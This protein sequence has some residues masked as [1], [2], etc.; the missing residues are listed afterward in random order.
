MNFIHKLGK[1]DAV[2]DQRTLQLANYIKTLPVLPAKVNWSSKLTRPWGMMKN[3][4]V[5][6]CT[7]AAAGHM[8]MSWAAD[9][10][11][12]VNI[13][14]GDIIRSYV[15]VTAAENGGAGYDPATGDNDTGC[16]EIDV[17]NYWRKTGIAGHKIGAYAALEPHN[18]NSL[19]AAV[20]IFGGAYTGFALPVSAQMQKVWSIPPGGAR[21]WG[22]PGSWGGHAVPVVDYNTT[23][24]VCVTWGEL[25]QMTWGFYDT[26]CEE[27]YA[28][29]SN[30]F[31]TGIKSASGF[32]MATLHADL[33]LITKK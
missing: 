27:S 30:D 33:K 12:V 32:D 3:D 8:I 10:K 2:H 18:N 11:R 20:Y 23:G 25:K 14:D 22:E 31:F 13:A 17:L 21:G 28:I 4:S 5:G 16:V 19:K 26:Y 29:I 6:D 15:D 9:N 1:K 24:P 7:I